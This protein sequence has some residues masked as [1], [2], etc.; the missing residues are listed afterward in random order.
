MT[1]SRQTFQLPARLSALVSALVCPLAI[2]IGFLAAPS[3]AHA[4]TLADIVDG[5]PEPRIIAEGFTFTEGPATDAKGDIY[6]SDLG[7]TKIHMW[8]VPAGGL[9]PAGTELA[10]QTVET[11]LDPSGKTN[12]LF[13]GQDGKLYGCQMDPHRRMVVIDPATKE[14]APLVERFEG[15]RLN[16]PNDLFI[17]ASG[18]IWFS[19]PAYDRKPE[20]I[21]VPSE[22]VYWISPDRKTV[23]RVAEGFKRPNGVLVSPDGKLLYI[24]DR[25]GNETYVYP[26]LGPGELGER[27]K[28]CDY[29]CDGLAFDEHGNVY[30]TPKKPMI[31]VFAPDGTL[32]GEI[33]LPGNATNVTFGGAD[34]KTLFITARDKVLALPMK[35]T[36]GG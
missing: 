19:D 6:F 26:I 27:K 11:W 28:F 4:D 22:A 31:A 1:V 32:V 23:K 25:V 14:I 9:P 16:N 10:T 35:L 30:T 5:K 33:P 12:G 20:E 24:S 2:V 21:E 17:D 18:A 29:G 34:H 36:G 15:K 7:T 8:K 3:T 13:W